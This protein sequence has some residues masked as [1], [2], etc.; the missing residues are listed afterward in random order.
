[1]ITNTTI[2]YGSKGDASVANEVMLGSLLPALPI[3]VITLEQ[4]M[5]ALNRSGPALY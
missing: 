1:M 4:A 2:E 3:Q 5:A